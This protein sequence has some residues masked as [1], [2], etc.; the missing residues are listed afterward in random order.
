MGLSVE[1]GCLNLCIKTFI[2]SIT[3]LIS[4]LVSQFLNHFRRERGECNSKNLRTGGAT[5]GKAVKCL[6][7]GGGWLIVGVKCFWEN[8]KPSF[9]THK[10]RVLEVHYTLKLGRPIFSEYPKTPPSNI[11]QERVQ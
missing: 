1:H 2:E 9:G 7:L 5:I 4:E 11:S 10:N 6:R 3:P 8:T